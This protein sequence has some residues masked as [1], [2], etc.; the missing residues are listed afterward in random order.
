MVRVE[1][2]WQNE[3]GDKRNNWVTHIGNYYHS[4]TPEKLAQYVAANHVSLEPKDEKVA[5]ILSSKICQYTV[6][7]VKSV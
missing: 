6:L 1:F 4:S 5:K 7:E 2:I 3:Y